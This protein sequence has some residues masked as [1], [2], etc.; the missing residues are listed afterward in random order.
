MSN[1]QSRQPVG[2]AV[3]EPK[4][5]LSEILEQTFVARLGEVEQAQQ[6]LSEWDKEFQ[7]LKNQLQHSGK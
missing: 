3:S 2:Y 5:P 1:K 7:Q 6:K 4:K